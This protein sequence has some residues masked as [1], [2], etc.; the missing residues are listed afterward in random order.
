MYYKILNKVLYKTD[1]WG[2]PNRA[3]SENVSFGTYDDK[4]QTFLVT[5][6]DGRV[7]LKDV[8]G[9]MLR[10]ISEVGVEARFDSDNH[11]ILRM[12]DGR[13]CIVD[14]A[15]NVRRFFQ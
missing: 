5:R 8:N 9:N 15:G 10:I 14:R 12:K 11:I 3:I 4:T 2:N 13:T 6:L 7:E 1:Q